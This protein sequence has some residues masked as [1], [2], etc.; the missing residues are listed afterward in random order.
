MRVNLGEDEGV[1]VQMAPLIDC[2]FLL[3]IF[4]LV[5]TTLKEKHR[6]IPIVLPS[7]DA[8]VEVETRPETIVLGVDRYG[9]KYVNGQAVSITAVFEQ[10]RRAKEAGKVFRLD[11]DEETPYKRILEVLEICHVEGVYNV[12]L[13]TSEDKPRQ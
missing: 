9:Q 10:V 8:A 5:A 6:E 4:F 12:G 11:A 2:V 3:L 13:H 7:S 1:E